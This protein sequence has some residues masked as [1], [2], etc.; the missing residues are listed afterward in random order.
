MAT[1]LST[2]RYG[3]SKNTVFPAACDIISSMRHYDPRI[4][5]RIMLEPYGLTDTRVGTNAVGGKVTA[6]SSGTVKVST[7]PGYFTM[8]T[9]TTDNDTVDYTDSALSLFPSD[10]LYLGVKFTP[11]AITNRIHEIGF[12][13]H[14]TYASLTEKFTVSFNTESAVS[15]ANWVI[16]VTDGTDTD[17]IDTGVAAGAGTEVFIELEVETDGTCHVWIN[18]AE[19]DMSTVTTVLTAATGFSWIIHTQALAAAATTSKWKY[20]EVITNK[21]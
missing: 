11:A 13:D 2:Y 20:V 8:T 21:D 4:H 6:A 5:R 12:V 3:D 10:S 16:T 9:P 7:A 18:G 14:L 1:K 17:T 19:I 15:T